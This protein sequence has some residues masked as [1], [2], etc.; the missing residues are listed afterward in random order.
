MDIKF[1][2]I[3][4]EEKR[5][6]VN[7]ETN[8]PDPLNDW[9]YKNDFSQY[10]RTEYSISL[11]LNK[12]PKLSL[13]LYLNPNIE[14]FDVELFIPLVIYKNKYYCYAN[15]SYTDWN[16]AIDD[17]LCNNFP[18]KDEDFESEFENLNLYGLILPVKFPKTK[19]ILIRDFNVINNGIVLIDNEYYEIST[20]RNRK[21]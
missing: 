5:C 18:Y 2:T 6:I 4:T 15:E 12:I 19:N 14:F 16:Y 17:F 13:L 11:D 10:E 20:Q 3:I 9:F 1:S 7:G 21:P 8:H